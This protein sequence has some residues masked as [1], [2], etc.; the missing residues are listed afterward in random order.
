MI[1]GP[2]PSPG[3][4]IDLARPWRLATAELDRAVSLPAPR[5]ML[6][7]TYS[8][9]SG[10]PARSSTRSTNGSRSSSGSGSRWRTRQTVR[11]ER[12]RLVG[13]RSAWCS[14][15]HETSVK[16]ARSQPLRGL[17]G[18]RRSSRARA[19]RRSSGANGS[20]RG[21]L[22]GQPRGTRRCCPARRTGPPA[23]RRASACGAAPRTAR[24][25]RGSSG[26]WRWRRRRR[27]ARAARAR[28]GPGRGSSPG[29]RAPPARAR[30]SRAPRRRRRPV[31]RGHA[32][33]PARR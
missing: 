5:V 3:S 16:P 22:V 20:S 28:P 2:I 14:S 19:S 31:P 18:G 4:R 29:R 1:S 7:R 24:R 33:G 6:S 15:Q 27:P 26:R 25:G 8:S 12:P 10:S 32:V 11:D 30:P 9:T 17:L 13:R 21:D 23:A